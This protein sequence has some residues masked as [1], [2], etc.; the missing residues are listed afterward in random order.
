MEHAKN[1]LAKA[2]QAA[3]AAP[4]NQA[5]IQNKINQTQAKLEQTKQLITATNTELVHEQKNASTAPVD[6][7][8]TT[9]SQFLENLEI[10]RIMKL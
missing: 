9:Y 5:E 10:I 3:S 4:Q 1:E 8:N 2:E 7:R 6:L